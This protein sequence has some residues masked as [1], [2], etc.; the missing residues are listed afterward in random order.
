MMWSQRNSDVTCRTWRKPHFFLIEFQVWNPHLF[1][2]QKNT[3]RRETS[4]CRTVLS[5]QIASHF[6]WST[7]RFAHG[8]DPSWNDGNIQTLMLHLTYGMFMRIYIYIII[9]EL[10]FKKLIFTKML[11]SSNTKLDNFTIIKGFQTK[12]DTNDFP[13]IIST[14]MLV[15][16]FAYR[17]WDPMILARCNAYRW[18]LAIET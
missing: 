1:G 7:S 3:L 9:W 16:S 4:R 12:M 6:A 17:W 2:P 18:C 11:V 14:K 5:C 13:I 15:S 10:C 8:M